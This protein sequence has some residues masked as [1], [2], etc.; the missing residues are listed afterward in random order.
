MTT[1]DHLTYVANMLATKADEV[2]MGVAFERNFEL[3]QFV[4]SCLLKDG[5]MI[6]IVESGRGLYEVLF[7]SPASTSTLLEFGKFVKVVTKAPSARGTNFT[8]KNIKELTKLLKTL[9]Y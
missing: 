9:K 5:V 8:V 4:R 1:N 2:F 6:S 7:Y 3:L